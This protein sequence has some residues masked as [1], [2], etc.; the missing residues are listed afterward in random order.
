MRGGWLGVS[1]RDENR[2]GFA[3]QWGTVRMVGAFLGEN[4][5]AVPPAS[6]VAFASEQLGIADPSCLG[7]YAERSK[8]AYETS[9]VKPLGILSTGGTSPGPP[10]DPLTQMAR[11]ANGKSESPP[12]GSAGAERHAPAAPAPS[13]G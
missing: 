10:G 12:G 8:T 4:P 1:V 5:T 11:C 2:L 9:C 3:V 13:C 7:A 6:V